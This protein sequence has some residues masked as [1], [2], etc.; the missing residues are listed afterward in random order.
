MPN[1]L[2]T[3]FFVALAL[4]SAAGAAAQEAR[5]VVHADRTVHPISRYLTGACIEDVN[6]EIYGGLYSQMIFGESFQEPPSSH[7]GR[8]LSRLWR[9][10]QRG[11]AAGTWTIESDRPFVGKQ[12]Q[13]ITFSEGDGQIGVE[14]QGLNR[15]GMSFVAGKPYEGVLWARGE[16]PCELYVALEARHGSRVYA[17]ERLNVAADAWQR[18]TFT[19]T[20]NAADASGRFAITLQKPGSVALGYAFLQ[21]GPWGRFK[22]LPVRRDVVEG[23][24]DQGITVLRYGGSMV[25]HAAVPLEKNARPA[26][27][28]SSQSRL[29]VS[30]LVQRLG[31]PRLPRSLPGGRLSGHPG[32]QHGRDAARHGRLRRIRQWSGDQR[33]GPSPRRRRTPRAVSSHAHGTGQ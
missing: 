24:I 21:P 7:A 20:P 11:T 18:L 12:C 14:N 3:L 1:R 23:L 8:E 16:Q 15:W 2:A 10:V 5:I 22:G 33:L 6:H 9:A 25:N 29:L 31:H 17:Q 4:A 28:P 19:L 27:P 26:R 13:R 30:L 32:L